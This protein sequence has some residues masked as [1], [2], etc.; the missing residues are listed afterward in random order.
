MKY[1]TEE[2]SE[3]EK[4]HINGIFKPESQDKDAADLLEKA[5]SNIRVIAR[6]QQEFEDLGARAAAI[7][8][9]VCIYPWKPKYR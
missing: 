4:H 2:W 6:L 1:V 3:W 8:S 9:A 7:N 5:R